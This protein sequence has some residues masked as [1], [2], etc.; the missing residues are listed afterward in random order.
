MEPDLILWADAAW[1]PHRYGRPMQIRPGVWHTV[2]RHARFERWDVAL[3]GLMLATAIVVL[4]T[5]IDADELESRPPADIVGWVA[6][7]GICLAL[8]GRRRWPLRTIAVVLALLLVLGA[9]DNADTIGFLALL[10]RALQRRC[11]PRLSDSRCVRSGCCWRC[12]WSASPR[13]TS[14]RPPD[15]SGPPRHSLSGE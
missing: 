11:Q 5:R 14:I 15:S 9:T 8:V 6:T 13:S 1:N 10:D 12:W 2:R 3:A 4:T 7:I